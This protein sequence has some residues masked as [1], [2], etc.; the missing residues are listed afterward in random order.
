MVVNGS[1]PLKN[2]HPSYF[3]GSTTP[4]GTSHTSGPANGGVHNEQL[5]GPLRLSPNTRNRLARQAQNGGMSP[6]D[7]SVGQSE[8]LREDVAHLSPVYETRTPSPTASRK[9]DLA[10]DRK[11][12]GV[13]S[14]AAEEK[15]EISTTGQKL[16]A[17]DGNQS[18]QSPQSSQSN[19]HSRG[20]KSE[21]GGT[22]AW[23]KIPKS[24]KRGTA[25]EQKSTGIGQAL[26]ER[27]PNNASERKG[28]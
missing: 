9:F 19:G 16:T 10:G 11:V 7:I 26:S 20:S 17:V 6:L 2:E 25:S 21:G 3:T 23:Q 1:N 14:K 5:N 22:N 24:K 15:L 28:G 13:S 4:D 12:N 8:V 27:L 18:K